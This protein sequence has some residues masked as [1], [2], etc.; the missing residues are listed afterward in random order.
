MQ[1]KTLVLVIIAVIVVGVGLF[2]LAGSANAAKTYADDASPVMYFYREDCHF[3]QQQAPILQELALDGY[4]VKLMDV[5]AHAE[6][7]G[8]YNIS[9]TP[10]FLAPNGDRQVGLT[11]KDTLRPWL[12]Q[13]NARIAAK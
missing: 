12:D 11:D 8:Q 5:G 13:H 2:L 4:R 6:Y 7:W 3:C 9:G 1:T 10:T